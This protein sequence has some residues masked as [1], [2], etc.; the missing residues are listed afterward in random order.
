MEY[1][2]ATIEQKDF[3]AVLSQTPRSMKGACMYCNHCLPCP[4]H[5][6]IAA[7]SQYLDLALVSEKIP[8]TVKAHYMGLTGHGSD[9]IQC[10]QCEER[11]PFGVPVRDRMRQA[12]ELF[13]K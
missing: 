2:T 3:G 5:L 1:E 9:C 11:C 4:S 6:D 10:G 8:D 12:A 7:I 13:G